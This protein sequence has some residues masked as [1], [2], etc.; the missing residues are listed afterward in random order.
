MGYF[1]TVLVLL[2]TSSTYHIP[3]ISFHIGLRSAGIAFLGMGTEDE[4]GPS[5]TTG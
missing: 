4:L 3:C 2:R 5:E 1:I